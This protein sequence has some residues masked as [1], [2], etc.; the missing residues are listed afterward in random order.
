MA[1]NDLRP[2]YFF[3]LKA[4]T[5]ITGTIF[6]PALLALVLRRLYDHLAYAEIIF[7]ASLIV[8]LVL[9][10]LMVVKKVQRYGE[11]YKK[12]TS[13]PSGGGSSGS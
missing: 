11:E 4:M 12:L 9:T 2:Y 1:G 10:M 7:F 5:D 6:I 3:A 8:I 13:A